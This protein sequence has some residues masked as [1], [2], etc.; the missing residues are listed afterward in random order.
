MFEDL[1]D[2]FVEALLK[3]FDFK[4]ETV[5]HKLL[6]NQIPEDLLQ[7]KHSQISNPLQER[8][9]IY[10]ADEFDIKSD[11]ILESNLILRGR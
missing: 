8:K 2:G 9:S 1:E 10:D 3:R 7:K 11:Q 6:E 4:V 5:I